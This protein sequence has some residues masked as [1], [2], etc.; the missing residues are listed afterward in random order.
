MTKTC[1]ERVVGGEW[2]PCVKRAREMKELVY[3]T[4]P[5]RAYVDDAES[6]SDS[7]SSSR[8]IRLITL[9]SKRSMAKRRAGKR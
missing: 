1:Y 5:I 3:P 4:D 9:L 8:T 7:E 2:D 6:E